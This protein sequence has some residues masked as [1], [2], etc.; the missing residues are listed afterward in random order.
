MAHIADFREAILD[1]IREDS[2]RELEQTHP[3]Q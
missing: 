3:N 1:Y 2:I